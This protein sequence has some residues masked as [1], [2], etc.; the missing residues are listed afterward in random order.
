[1]ALGYEDR[2]YAWRAIDLVLSGIEPRFTG[3]YEHVFYAQARREACVPLGRKHPGRIRAEARG[4][5]RA[6]GGTA[7]GEEERVVYSTKRPVR[8]DTWT[9]LPGGAPMVTAVS[10]GTLDER[11]LYCKMK[12]PPQNT[13]VPLGRASTMRRVR[14]ITA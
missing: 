2:R 14:R 5:G 3:C 10:R 7:E 1:M 8:Y 6:A 13:R 12:C 9:N 11:R 4:G